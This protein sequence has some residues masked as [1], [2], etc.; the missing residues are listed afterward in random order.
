MASRIPGRTQQGIGLGLR[1]QLL[2][3]IAVIQNTGE[4][5]HPLPRPLAIATSR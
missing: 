4:P 1:I 3:R 5:L 2:K